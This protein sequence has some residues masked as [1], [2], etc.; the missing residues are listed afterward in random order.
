LKGIW[1]MSE[2]TCKRCSVARV[3]T[4][5][6]VYEKAHLGNDPKAFHGL[7]EVVFLVQ[8]RG[9]EDIFKILKPGLADQQLRSFCWNVSSFLEDEEMQRIFDWA[10]KHK[11][12]NNGK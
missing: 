5:C 6:E 10:P 3:N 11:N 4:L 2:Q 12:K 9:Y 7:R 1:G 8:S